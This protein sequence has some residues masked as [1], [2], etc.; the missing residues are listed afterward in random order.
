M[1]GGNPLLDA[2]IDV[3]EREL[4]RVEPALARLWFFLLG[5]HTKPFLLANVAHYRMPP[6]YCAHKYNANQ[7]IG[8]LVWV[9]CA[10]CYKRR[11]SVRIAASRPG[12]R[13][14]RCAAVEFNLKQSNRA[15]SFQQPARR[16]EVD[17]I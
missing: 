8:L 3:V 13:S 5:F 15:I 16:L 11:I 10:A 17:G 4:R 12:Q 2:P 9:A 6:R 7:A 14:Q 1:L